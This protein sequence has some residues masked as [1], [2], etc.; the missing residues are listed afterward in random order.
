MKSWLPLFLIGLV[1]GACIALAYFLLP[2]HAVQG[3]PHL[4]E[5]ASQIVPQEQ[6]ALI[7]SISENFVNQA[8]SG[9]STTDVA[10]GTRIILIPHHLVA[11]RYIASLLSSVP[12]PRRIILLAPDHLGVGKTPVTVG[13]GTL[14]FNGHAVQTDTSIVKKILAAVPQAR[15][16]EDAIRREL[17]IQTLMPFLSQ[18]FPKSSVTP[19]LMQI[20]RDADARAPLA[21]VIEKI[22]QDDPNILLIS[23]V[24]FSHYLP[25]EVADIHDVLAMDVISGLADQETD[26]IELDSAGVLAVT[27]KT[28]RDLGLGDVTIQAHTNSLR[29]LQSTIAQESTS[30]I[31]ASFAS[32]PIE[33]Q[34]TSVILFTG[35]VMLDR[36]VKD[37][38]RASHDVNTPFENIIGEEERFFRGQDL[39]VG[40]LEGPVTQIYR[41]PEK[42]NDFAFASS[43]PSLLKRIGFDAVSQANNHELDQGRQGADDS[44]AALIRSGIVPFGDQVRDLAT[45]SL[46]ILERRGQRIALIGL[47]DS[48]HRVDLPTAISVIQ[49]AKQKADHVIVFMHWGEEYQAKPTER[50]SFLAYAFIDAGADAVIGSHPHWMESVE[51]YKGKPIAYSLGNFVFDQDWSTET[52]FGLV[53]GLVLSPN[54]FELHLLPISIIK[55]RPALLTG[56]AR[57]KRLDYLAGISD[58][59]LAEGIKGGVVR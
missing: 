40:N 33:P 27:L 58:P 43:T 6:T 23:T 49:S 25:A 35:D 14:N 12:Q 21:T 10:P 59:A 31:L 39:V 47:N 24:D 38:M 29:I 37:R 28:A 1:V 7:P 48:D 42:E 55:S 45:S 51:V 15:S 16:D 17:S 19:V 22:L 32:G 26:R 3:L 5:T 9:V 36:A 18:A 44:H 54:N 30:H 13:D 56:D 53:V 4:A 34:Q 41:S 2:I 11:A 57:Q 52:R 46:V 50:Q 8:F 20:G